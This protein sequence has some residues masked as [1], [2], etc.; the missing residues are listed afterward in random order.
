M[1]VKIHITVK[2]KILIHLLSYSRYKEEVE[3]P[4]QVSQEGMAKAVGVRRSHI[5]SALK[6]LKDLGHVEEKKARVIGEKRR[7]NAYFLTHEGQAEALRLKEAVLEKKILLKTEDGAVK[8]IE[9]PRLK[10]HIEEKLGVLEILNRL[11]DEGVFDVKRKEEPAEEGLERT[12][13]CPFCAQTN[14]NFEL[15]EVELSSGGTGLSVT[16]FFCGREFLAAEISMA[17][18]EE[19]KGYAPTF[20]PSEITPEEYAPPPFVTANPF[21][22][23]LGLFFMLASFLLALMIGLDYV[24]SGF[25]VLILVGF[26]LSFALLYFGLMNVRHLDAIT[27]RILIVIGAIFV[28]FI[29]LFVGLMLDAE[30]EAEQTWIMASVVIPAF[31]VFIFGKPLAK[32]LRS[33]LSL[34]LGVFLVLFGSFTIIFFDLFSW[35][36]WYSPFW[37]IV[38]SMMVFT[39][40]EIERLDIIFVIR[41]GC[42]GVGAFMTLF[43]IVLMVQSGSALWPFRAISAI[44]W[45]LIGIYL[46][47]IRFQH[48]EA[49]EKSILALRGALLSGIGELFFLVGILLALNGR[50][51]ECAVEFFIGIPIIYYGLVEV[52]EYEPSQVG[53]IAFV[54]CS[55]ALTVLSFTLT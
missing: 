39:S 43:C 19:A 22:V 33:E 2:E 28:G 42:I 23:S 49:F 17:D 50:I 25:F 7:K 45:L 18:Q 27:R 4:V 1:A 37:V 12:V 3:V 24:S 15:K 5:A 16:C 20:L 30:Y 8:E 32:S 10:D 31:G 34:S 21:L 29:A 40:Y 41:A 44:L 51:M 6:D 36:A 47:L 52:R 13:I 55:E 14:K 48:Q 46:V 38:G 9:I 26:I 35:S 54:I 11:D 53:L